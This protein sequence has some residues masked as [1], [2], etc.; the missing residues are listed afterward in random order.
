MFGFNQYDV[1]RTKGNVTAIICG[2]GGG[3]AKLM[4]E[5]GK[6][7]VEFANYSATEVAR[8]FRVVG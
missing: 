6:N 5:D 1:I 7:G 2:W 8:L 3:F 4:F